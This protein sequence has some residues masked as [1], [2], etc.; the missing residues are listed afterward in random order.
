MTDLTDDS[1]TTPVT[2]TITKVT[3]GNQSNV[4]PELLQHATEEFADGVNF[5]SHKHYL[6]RKFNN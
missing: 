2:K 1:G 5:K 4:A 6:Q 3:N